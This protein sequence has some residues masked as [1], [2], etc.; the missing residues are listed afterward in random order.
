MHQAWKNIGCPMLR[1]LLKLLNTI[2]L[3]WMWGFLRGPQL[4]FHGAKIR[5]SLS[6]SYKF[7][8]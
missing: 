2:V 5:V 8:H 3:R 1:A 4:G 7:D 6:D